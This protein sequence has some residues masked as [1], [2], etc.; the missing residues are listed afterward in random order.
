M[1]ARRKPVC[2]R[3]LDAGPGTCWF[4]WESCPDK[5]K[6]CWGRFARE[7]QH[8][9]GDPAAEEE[10]KARWQAARDKALEPAP[11]ML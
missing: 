2:S 5:I 3:D 9:I 4:W 1:T 10:A 11:R 7:H 6:H 8:V